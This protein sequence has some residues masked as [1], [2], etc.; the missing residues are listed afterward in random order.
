MKKVRV[1]LGMSGGVDSSAAAYLLKEEGYEVVGITM[2]LIDNEKTE[3]SIK[4]A[5]DVC[6]YLGIEHHV[7]DL[8]DEFRNIVINDFI[9]C[10]KRGVTPNPCCVCN[11]FF[12]FGL[13][14]DKAIKLGCQLI[15]TG[16]YASI[17]DGKIYRADVLEKDQSYFLW[18]INKDVLKNVILPL[19]GFDNKE[20]VRKL[21]KK[22]GISVNNKKDSQEVCF[23]PNDDYKAYL[24]DNLD[25]KGVPGD[26]VLADGTILGKH[27]GLRNYTVG[28]RKGLNISYKEPLYVTKID[29]KNNNLIVGGSD[30][31]FNKSLIAVNINLL[32]DELPLK[33]YAKVRSRGL[34]KLCKVKL[35]D[36]EMVVDFVEDERAITPGQSVVLYSED[37]Q[38]L[39]GGI[40]K[41]VL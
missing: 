30:K 16:H 1:G 9:N 21:A 41:E 12:K 24:N 20:K 3:T 5:A 31:L 25:E 8:R 40:I 26:I 37:N 27:S 18:G 14:Y 10:Y 19:Q 33:I 28:Q 4:D 13:F 2:R 39:G 11:K 35:N 22:A 15:S 36:N 6:E 7:I 17:N 32:V 23:I 34:L 38:L 29:I